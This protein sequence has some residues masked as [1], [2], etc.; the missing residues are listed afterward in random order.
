MKV[1]DWSPVIE[2][3]AESNKTARPILDTLDF[4]FLSMFM[5]EICLK[6]IDNFKVFWTDYWNVFDFIVTTMVRE[7]VIV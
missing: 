5:A 1:V 7:L 2:L 4:F 6:W 3:D